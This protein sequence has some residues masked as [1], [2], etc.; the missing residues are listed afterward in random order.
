MSFYTSSSLPT[1]AFTQYPGAYFLS[2]SCV[3]RQKIY[4]PRLPFPLWVGRLV[5]RLGSG[6]VSFPEPRKAR[7][8]AGPISTSKS[9][10]YR[11]RRTSIHASI[12]IDHAAPPMSVCSGV[13][14][15]TDRR[16][17]TSIEIERSRQRRSIK[18][19]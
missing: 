9:K 17:T 5:T 16:V 2:N 14:S 3:K 11:R 10:L 19:R 12:H 13:F 4:V 6:I 15:V 1:Y 18:A 8:A 7:P